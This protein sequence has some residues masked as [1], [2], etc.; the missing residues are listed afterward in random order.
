ML[1]PQREAVPGIVAWPHTILVP[2]GENATERAAWAL[3]C[4][5]TSAS[6]DAMSMH[7]RR[8]RATHASKVAHAVGHSTFYGTGCEAHAD[9][10]HTSIRPP[11][12][13][14]NRLRM[15]RR[16]R[17][18]TKRCRRLHLPRAFRIS[19]CDDAPRRSPHRAA[20]RQLI[21]TQSEWCEN[22]KVTATRTKQARTAVAVENTLRLDSVMVKL[23]V[24]SSAPRRTRI[25][26][27]IISKPP[28][29]KW[30]FSR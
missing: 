29:V 27:P 30:T 8:T 12:P 28:L 23:L 25:D 18:R 2:S 26:P 11:D 21:E 13:A 4:S 15:R 17:N 3:V 24:V 5:V 1:T 16:A 19:R 6:V 20:R 9:S 22:A 7:L 14:L 10:P